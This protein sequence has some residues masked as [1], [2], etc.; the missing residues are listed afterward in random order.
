MK[1]FLLI[2]F[3]IFLFFQIRAQQL[4]HEETI[5]FRQMMLNQQKYWNM[6]DIDGYMSFYWGSDSLLFI[7]GGK[8]KKGWQNIRDSYEKKYP[9]SSSRGT[10]E[11]GD[12]Y[13]YKLAKKEV[14]IT[15][16]WKLIRQS[17]DLGGSFTLIWKKINGRWV[18]VLDHTV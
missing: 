16:S 7:S 4:T 13:F 1:R 6:G 3:F 18:I 11:F 15:G 8:A 5:Y 14:I 9:D 17:G 2:F 12:L 10:L